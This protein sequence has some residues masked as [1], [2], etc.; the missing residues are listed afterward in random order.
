MR[1]DVVFI[2]DNLGEGALWGFQILGILIAAAT[3][4]T[5]LTPS[6]SRG[7]LLSK[8]LRALNLLA[9]NVRHNRNADDQ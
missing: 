7:V 5:A 9:G 2:M 1:M 4:I 6:R 8:A 3:V